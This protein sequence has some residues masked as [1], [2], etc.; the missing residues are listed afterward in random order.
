MIGALRVR[1]ALDAYDAEALPAGS[2]RHDPALGDA[3]A[4]AHRT[5]G[6]GRDVFGFSVQRHAARCWKA[7]DLTMGSSGGIS[8]I[9]CCHSDS[10]AQR[11]PG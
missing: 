10:P 1:G 11:G 9:L 6:R 2:F 5:C 3:R 8:S 7:L 4:A